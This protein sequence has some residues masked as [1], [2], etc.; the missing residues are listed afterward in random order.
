[1]SGCCSCSQLCYF[2][3]AKLFGST[4]ETRTV[5]IVCRRLGGFKKHFVWCTY[6]LITKTWS[7]E[8]SYKKSQYF[9]P[10]H[11]IS[12]PA[13]LIQRRSQCRRQGFMVG[14]YEA[15]K[16]G[17]ECI[18]SSHTFKFSDSVFSL[19]V[20]SAGN[21]RCPF[22]Q[23]HVDNLAR[24]SGTSF[25]LWWWGADVLQAQ[26]FLRSEKDCLLTTWCLLEASAT[27][28]DWGSHSL[29][30][31]DWTILSISGIRVLGNTSSDLL[32][33]KW[34][35]GLCSWSGCSQYTCCSRSSYSGFCWA[36][37]KLI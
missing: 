2:N 19:P 26:S 21:Y 18:C 8:H 28:S 15:A 25:P 5:K 17:K 10:M 9:A 32:V 7:D 1:M 3:S 37:H 34:S 11:A 6:R 13:D 4:S 30:F 20:D 16:V 36:S 23:Q 12:L 24:V 27:I 35:Y 29:A 31:S 14:F 33:G 22:W